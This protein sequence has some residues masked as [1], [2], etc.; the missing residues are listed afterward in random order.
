MNFMK[1]IICNNNGITISYLNML[2]I[3]DVGN[4]NIYF[5]YP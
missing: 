5:F 2:N 4:K 1:S 3:I